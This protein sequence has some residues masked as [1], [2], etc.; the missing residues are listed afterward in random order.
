[1]SLAEIKR[2]LKIGSKWNTFHVPFNKDMGIREVS[3]VQTNGVYFKRSD[4]KESFLDFPSAKLVS[5]TPNGFKVYQLGITDVSTGKY[6]DTLIELV[7]CYEEIK[8]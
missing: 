2:K 5:L 1:M 4:G 3:R 6:D 8:E 7:L